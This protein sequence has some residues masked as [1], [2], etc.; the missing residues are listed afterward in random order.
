MTGEADA[1]AAGAASTVRVVDDAA[2]RR[3]EAYLGDE[4]AGWVTYRF[5]AGRIVF[6]HTEVP[7]AY[8]GRGIGARLAAGALDDARKRGLR[9]RAL[10]P[11]VAAY[12]E[13][14]PQYRDLLAEDPRN[15]D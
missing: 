11:F 1:G 5:V 4:L 6:V 2:M 14:H 3:Y 10:C 7:S 8:A 12:I 9:V 13:R 15:A